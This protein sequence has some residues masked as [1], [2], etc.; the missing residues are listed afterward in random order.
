MSSISYPVLRE[1]PRG[2]LGLVMLSH[3]CHRG[4]PAFEIEDDSWMSN[5]LK[6]IKDW[7]LARAA[8]KYGRYESGMMKPPRVRPSAAKEGEQSRTHARIAY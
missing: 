1:V 5:I 8:R 6:C 3:H 2:W 4:M 7:A